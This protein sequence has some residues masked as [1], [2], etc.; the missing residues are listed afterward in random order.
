MC[1]F[2]TLRPI[3]ISI[4]NIFSRPITITITIPCLL[5]KRH[6]KTIQPK[7]SDSAQPDGQ[8]LLR[9]E[10][11]RHTTSRQHHT[12]QQRQFQAVGLAILD[13]IAAESVQGADGATCGEGGHGARADVACDSAPGREAGEDVGDLAGGGCGLVG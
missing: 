6:P 3:L 1:S 12:G 5:H 10:R 11:A 4:G 7:S 8:R 9:L 2:V 13:A